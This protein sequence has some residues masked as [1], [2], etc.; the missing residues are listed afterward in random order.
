MRRF[1]S[2]QHR[3]ACFYSCSR[4]ASTTV[5]L[6]YP[7]RLRS[8]HL[9]TRHLRLACGLDLGLGLQSRVLYA[10]CTYIGICILHATC[11]LLKAQAKKNKKKKKKKTRQQQPETETRKT[12]SL[13]LSLLFGG[14]LLVFCC[15]LVLAFLTYMH[16]NTPNISDISTRVSL[17]LLGAGAGNLL[18]KTPSTRH[19]RTALGLVPVP[20]P[21]QH[22][23]TQTPRG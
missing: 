5:W 17:F 23:H 3:V 12:R 9:Q 22:Q 10:A 16:N 21:V 8:L 11:S 13:G 2:Q 7:S 19:M 6:H 20:V 1:K 4:K 14:S 15:L 18:P